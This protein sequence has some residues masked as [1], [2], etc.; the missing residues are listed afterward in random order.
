MLLDPLKGRA[1]VDEERQSRVDALLSK[2]RTICMGRYLLDV[3]E[4]ARV[5]YGPASAPYP[6]ERL[7]SQAARLNEIVAELVRDAGANKSKHPIGHSFA[8][9][10]ME[11]WCGTMGSP[12][13]KG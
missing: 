8:S 10:V 11:R 7:S 9:R 13:M 12:N 2:R 3:P 1:A 6:I 4:S 5:V